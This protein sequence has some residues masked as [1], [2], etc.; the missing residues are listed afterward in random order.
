MIR[1][2]SIIILIANLIIISGCIQEASYLDDFVAIS[3][4]NKITARFSLKDDSGVYVKGDGIG[5]IKIVNS[6]GDTVYINNINVKKKD[7]EQYWLY[8]Q[9]KSIL[10]YAWKI[11]I[12]D[13]KKSTS[14]KGRMYL[15]FK[16]KN[17]EFEEIDTSILGKFP[18]YSKEEFA[19]LNDEEFSKSAIT[20]NKNLST[21][22]FE[23]TVTKIGFFTPLVE[24]G[25]KEEY[26]RVDMIVKNIGNKKERFSP[27]FIIFD[28]IGNQYESTYGGTFDTYS[29]IYPGVKKIGYV[30]FKKIPKNSQNI[31]LFFELGYGD[32]Y[33]T[34]DFEF[35]I[36]HAK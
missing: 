28:D 34:Y 7:F 8:G 9:N 22:K 6:Y 19:Q 23:V 11:P 21:G 16:M 20:V 18:T 36:S 25:D 2:F 33:Q 10:A 24:S 13:I 12:T 31:K 4:E 1:E 15:K 35:N 3:D 14:S 30:L 5:Q 29:E 17:S 26:F 32:S 27:S